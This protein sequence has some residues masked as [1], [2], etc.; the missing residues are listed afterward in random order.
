MNEAKYREAER[1]LW[2]SI[3]REP[4]ER[5]VVLRSTGTRVRVQE[6]GAGESVLF[7]H[8]GPN[9]GSTWA[10]LLE[11][12]EGYRCL[13]VDR[14]GT[15]LSD[16]HPLTPAELAGGF[17]ATFVGDVLDG[18]GVDRAH[19]VASLFLWG[20]DDTFGGRDVAEHVVALMGDARLEMMPA[21][22]HLPWLDDPAAA[23]LATDAF[24]GAGRRADTGTQPSPSAAGPAA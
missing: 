3:G 22:S 15:G 20:A 24:L 13:L 4:S 12:L 23:A 9:A 16:P 11:H 14:P 6:V 5:F 17:G 10:P 1:K 18:L 21:A 8:G 7:I 2:T 19:V